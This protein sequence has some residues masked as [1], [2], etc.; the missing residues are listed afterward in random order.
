MRFPFLALILV[1]AF[2][3]H[4]GDAFE[5]MSASQRA[6]TGIDKLTEQEREALSAWI[7]DEKTQFHDRKESE[8]VGFRES[9]QGRETIQSSIVGPF[10]GWTGHTE[11]QLANGQL[12]VQTEPGVFYI[13]STDNPA[14]EIRPRSMGSW[15]LYVD[16]YSRGVKV[17][18]IK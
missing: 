8:K 16:G 18:R 13:R 15:S 10:K 5:K 1:T 14:I 12:W 3:L 4:A 6:A 17:K 9:T 11:F 2:S 7:A